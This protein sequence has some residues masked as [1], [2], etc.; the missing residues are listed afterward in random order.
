M[1][2]DKQLSHNEVVKLLRAV[3]DDARL[4][5]SELSDFWIVA[6]NS[7][8]MAPRSVS[9]LWYLV[10]QTHKAAAADGLFSLTTAGERVAAD[11][12][13]DFLKRIG[14][15][16]FPNLNRDRVGIDL[17]MRVGNP[18]AM[19]Q[20]K[21][22]L[23]GPVAFLY[24]LASDTPLTYADFAIEL[25]EKGSS[26]IGDMLIEPSK[27]CRNY[28]PPSTMSPGDWLTAASLRDFENWWFDVDDVSVGFSAGTSIGDIENGLSARATATLNPRAILWRAWIGATSTT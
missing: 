9:M 6:Q 27:G 7:N 28:S 20:D 15:G 10:E 23:C 26:K 3:L 1:R 11:R 24:G 25:Y 16:F 21:A 18:S 12:I 17:L 2:E 5:P 4:T 19:D 13:C 8:G 22:E 14:N